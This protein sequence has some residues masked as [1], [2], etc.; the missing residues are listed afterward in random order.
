MVNQCSPVEYCYTAKNNP[1]MGMTIALATLTPSL[2]EGH[3]L[4]CR[5]HAGQGGFSWYQGGELTIIIS[6]FSVTVTCL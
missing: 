2:I 3:S 6:V 4:V 1:D 5:V